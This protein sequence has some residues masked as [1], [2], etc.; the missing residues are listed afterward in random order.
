MKNS[1]H[2][3]K[4]IVKELLT[5]SESVASLARKYNLSRKTLYAW[6]NRYEGAYGRGRGDSLKSRYVKGESHPREYRHKLKARIIEL[7]KKS[8]HLTTT[9]M[10]QNL[11]AGRHAVYSLLRDL[12]LTTE[13]SRRNF[14][15]LY[16][17]PGVF[18][19]SMKLSIVRS[20][21]TDGKKISDLSREFNVA[22]KTIYRWISEYNSGSDLRER[23]VRGESH[24]RSYTPEK[25]ERILDRVRTNPEFSIAQISGTL[26]LSAHGV[27]NVLLRHGLTKRSSRMYF[28]KETPA[29][30]KGSFYGFLEKIKSFLDRLSPNFLPAPPPGSTSVK[31]VLTTFFLSFFVSSISA[32]LFLYF[33][34]AFSASKDLNQTVGMFFAAI[35]LSAGSFFFLYSLKYYLTLAIVLSFS[36]KEHG[37][38]ENVG[39]AEWLFGTKN[40]GKNNISSKLNGL[41][42]EIAD[43][44][45]KRKPFVSVQ[46]P[47]YNERNVVERAI[48]ASTNF[49]YPEYEVILCDDSTDE[50]TEK[51]KQF[52]LSCLLP[53][54][55]LK[56]TKGEGW[57]MREVE[58]R[59]GVVL[60]H[61]HRYSRVGFKGKA[62]DLASQLMDGRAE[63]V[64]I[65]DADFV[66]YP[67]TLELFVKYFQAAPNFAA[68]QGY[69]WH[70]LNKSENWITRGVRSE[71]A[72]SYVIERSGIEVYGGLKQ[73]S[74]SVY[75]IRKEAL[76]SVGW[77]DSIT[78]DFEL[79]LRLYEKGYKVLYTPYI[80]A[81][82]ECA[83]TLKRLIRQRMRWA[84]GHSFNVK[85]MFLNLMTSPK[86]TLPEKME[87]LYLAP[88]YLQAF[89][90]IVGTL[91]W[92]ISEIVF[93]VRLPFWT[94]TWGWSL[95]LTNMISLPLVNTLGLFMEE[96]EDK[97]YTGLGSF[98]ILSYILVPF[99]AY[100]AVKGFL[101]K[102]E[103]PWFRTP[104]TGRVTDIFRPV[105]FA[106]FFHGIFDRMESTGVNRR[107]FDG[108]GIALKLVVKPLR[109]LRKKTKLIGNVAISFV[110][111]FALLI[112]YASS[113]VQLTEAAEPVSLGT[114]EYAKDQ[115]VKKEIKDI[116]KLP[117]TEMKNAQMFSF[118]AP[119]GSVDEIFYKDPRFRI[120][121]RGYEIEFSFLGIP[122]LGQKA[123]SEGVLEGKQVVYKNVHGSV[124]VELVASSNSVTE[125]IVINK[126]MEFSEIEFLVKG[127]GISPREEAGVISFADDVTG[128]T[129]FTLGAPY[130][131]EKGGTDINTL[132]DLLSTDLNYSLGL[133]YGMRKTPVGW[134]LK[135]RLTESGR[136]W[137]ADP[138]RTFP[139]VIDPSVIVSGGIV[140]TETQ[141][142]GLQRKV[143]FVNGN[144]YAFHNDE[145]DVFYKKSSDG[146]TWG[147]NVD[148]DSGDAD[149]YN[150]SI[151]VKGNTIWVVWVDD[152]GNTIEIRSIDT[153]SSDAL[154]TQTSCQNL[155]TAVDSSYVST[156]AVQSTGTDIFAAMTDTD[157][158]TIQ[159]VWRI[160]SVGTCSSSQS[161][162][163]NSGVGSGDR[164]VLTTLN[165]DALIVFQDGNLSY[166]RWSGID[167]SWVGS[168]ITIAS[169]TDNMYSV[170][171][172]GTT[173]WVLS[174]S[175]TTDTNFYRI[176]QYESTLDSAINGNLAYVDIA[177]PTS[178]DCK[179]VYTDPST[180][181]AY[182]VDCN[183]TACSSPTI[184]AITAANITSDSRRGGPIAVDC[185]AG[186]TDCK[187]VVGRRNVTSFNRVDFIDCDNAA[188]STSTVQ[189]I[190]NTGDGIPSYVDVYCVTSTDCKWI[191][192]ETLLSNDDLHF[193]D[194][195]TTN[196]STRTDTEID[197]D[198]GDFG[199]AASIYCTATDDCKVSYYDS[200]G[201]GS[202]EFLDCESDITDTDC[203]AGTA[204]TI[205]SDVG[206]TDT[207][208]S[209]VDCADGTLECRVVYY[210]S[211]DGDITF[212]DC[213]LSA[214]CAGGSATD[215]D[216]DVGSQGSPVSLECNDG[217]L[218]PDDCKVTYYDGTDQDIS[219]VDCNDDTCSSPAIVDID[220]SASGD[221]AQ[222]ALD[223]SLGVGDCQIVFVDGTDQD[224]SVADCE[225]GDCG[226]PTSTT[227]IDTETT[228]AHPLTSIDCP[229]ADNCKIIYQD[230]IEQDLVFVDCNDALCSSPTFTDLDTTLGRQ[231]VDSSIECP[232]SDDCK[233]VYWDFLS[234]TLKFVDCN[235]E[236]CGT[237]TV[238]NLDTTSYSYAS[239]AI[240][241]SAG[242][243]DCK[244]VYY[245]ETDRDVTFID[246][247]D[248]DC[249]SPDATTDIDTSAIGNKVDMDCVAADN[250]KVIYHD[251]GGLLF[252]D[253]GS[254]GC[255]AGAGSTS[256]TGAAEILPSN[257]SIDCVG[258]DT[259]CKVFWYDTSNG[260]VTFADCSNAQCSTTDSTNDIDTDVGAQSLNKIADMDCPTADNCKLIYSDASDSAIYFVDCE[261][262]TCASGSRSIVPIATTAT[263][264]GASGQIDCPAA[265]DC[266]A[267]VT[268]TKTQN[269]QFIDCMGENCT[270]AVL[271]SPWTSETNVLG[272]ALTYDSSNS[273][274][275]AHIVKDA[276]EQAYFKGTDAGTI[277]WSSETSYGFTTGDISNISAP[278][279]GAGTS[280]IGVVL[281]QNSNFEFAPLPESWQYLLISTVLALII[282]KKPYRKFLTK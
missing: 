128:E 3:K 133:E 186:A 245:D 97:D 92:L 85:K 230:F 42:S 144:W 215:I 212:Y 72:G 27:Y 236:S 9:E 204:T 39:L 31:S 255:G 48:K 246:C 81:P 17:F 175:G 157:A 264:I 112:N 249:S 158:G 142:G 223:C 7:V 150:P 29:P 95:V 99:Q 10:A 174:Q 138:E 179:I 124:D 254:T 259:D 199:G 111:I 261:A 265:D 45:L 282:L 70:V 141:F 69:Q 172:D 171:S 235:S 237:S 11:S 167:S 76:Q 214:T 93:K 266:K 183:D 153:A 276:S 108:T 143:A 5:S 238:S 55:K 262:G 213:N 229:A 200:N 1:A 132:D 101:E 256:L 231:G 180:S 177:C 136:A 164:P 126:R 134:V 178:G 252:F 14:A 278:M 21:I 41:S 78:E 202:I 257:I 152:S 135:K 109:G 94:E 244:V 279:S 221:S 68:V 71:Y 115:S 74:G 205:D 197:T 60:K 35:A 59:P 270:V 117:S 184:T 277:S 154:G 46:I 63:F 207:A 64:S 49:D 251:S 165:D 4:K 77:G 201:S 210:D 50:T 82:A 209:E 194:C 281:R 33:Y 163:S 225:D 114:V 239:S 189:S 102:K 25:V 24:P 73:I 185:S 130:M 86:L 193:V 26:G 232:A 240:D 243:T 36:Q 96:S 103:G 91:S 224:I 272:V 145:G 88:Y 168:N 226:S 242:A 206:I 32:T 190:I 22:R 271:S 37:T 198:V 98:V 122:E 147:D 274:L 173:T 83:S 43:L 65:F 66:P 151:W 75:M 146:V 13:V 156:I 23:Y 280:E 162:L 248:G 12:D 2:D 187:V 18:G 217:L 129:V 267:V 15:T 169:V 6:K 216:T 220:T 195:D 38:P 269:L 34:S 182:F 139:L 123:V 160:T 258:G 118:A 87:F 260:D 19:K 273:D 181:L 58:V 100:A 110:L 120:K 148:I 105:Q 247:E 90:F 61:L 67:D 140:D 159:D 54:E 263:L 53:G 234:S 104:K 28:A 176:G 106:R 166:S 62:L 113:F 268:H 192:I 161:I 119:E 56:E 47:F 8:P 228:P 40:P 52:Q 84:E 275:Y 116:Q 222:V 51:I 131:Y 203:N 121:N 57:I 170:A 79:T 127:T 125:K 16:A 211:T 20:H 233:V 219:F 191:F 227:D 188:C 250:C 218:G 30:Q 107:V 253:C 149:N 241:C 44:V 80:Q 137:I 89:F 208:Y 155:G 196:C